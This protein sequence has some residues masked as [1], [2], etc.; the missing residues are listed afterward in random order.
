MRGRSTGRSSG[1]A[2]SLTDPSGFYYGST[3]TGMPT[4][5]WWHWIQSIG[6]DWSAP[7]GYGYQLACSYWS[8]DLRLRRLTSGTWGSW[9]QLLHSNNYNSYVLSAS[10]TAASLSIGGS[11]AQ[12]NGQAA[13]YYENRD[14]T[15][16]G[17]SGGTLTLTR[18][19][20]N[21]SVSLDGRYL[22]GNQTITLGGD[23]SGSGTTSISATI[24][25]NA[26]TTTKI[27]NS[28]VTYAKIQNVSAASVLG[29]SSASVSQA[30]QEISF[31]SLNTL[32]S[33]TAK[34]WVTFNENPTTGAITVNANFGISSVTR[35]SLGVYQVNFSSAFTD[36]NYAVSGIIGYEDIGA[37]TNGGYLAMPRITS[38]KTT[39]YCQVCASYG[40]TNYNARYVH[41]VF[42]R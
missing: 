16:V 3:V 26:V 29:N 37:Y 8:D 42:H 21:L 25:A 41:V 39:T 12:L 30:P 4:T 27:N 18:A 38:P 1:T 5:D 14:T 13:S 2:N 40:G 31:T 22:T 17:F 19:A 15:A 20:G 34:A 24:G 23:L 33:G 7:D 6:N 32:L 9:V 10:G 36:A 28:A 11:A 35:L